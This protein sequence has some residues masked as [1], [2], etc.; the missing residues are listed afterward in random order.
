MIPR[1]I[2]VGTPQKH[3]KLIFIKPPTYDKTPIVPVLPENED[4][5]VVYVLSKKPDYQNVHAA[6]APAHEQTKPDVFF[7][8][9]RNE[10]EAQHQQH[11]IQGK[12][13]NVFSNFLL[14]S[15]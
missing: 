1:Y 6:E 3:L 14:I 8:K 7:V 12:F 10:A 9:Y 13:T 15:L 11:E 2:P 5:T 4:K